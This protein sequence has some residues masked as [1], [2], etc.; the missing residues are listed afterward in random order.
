MRKVYSFLVAAVAMITA[1]SCAQEIDNLST[2]NGKAIFTAYADGA[3]T[4]TVLGMNEE[5]EKPLSMWNGEEWIQIV[6]KGN[7]WMNTDTDGPSA[8]AKIYYNGKNGK[9]DE[10]DGVYAVYPAGDANYTLAKGLV[11]GVSVP[12]VQTATPDSYDPKAA[13]AIA[14][15]ENTELHFINVTSLLKFQVASEGVKSVT[16][17]PNGSDN[18]PKISG[19]CSIGADGALIPWTTNEHES[20]SYVELVA[21]DEG[22]KVGVDYYVALF[23]CTLETGFKVEFSF[24]GNKIEIASYNPEE[25]LVLPRN[26]I[27]NIGSLECEVPEWSIAG[28]LNNWNTLETPFVAEGDYWVAKSVSFK[29]SGKFKIIN[30]GSVWRSISE[31]FAVGKWFAISDGDDISI[32]AGT[33]DFYL[34]KDGKNLQVVSAGSAAPL[35]PG[36][37][38]AKEGWVYLKPNSNWTQAGARFAIYLCNGS[39]AAK[40]LSMSRVDGTS[41]YGVQLPDDYT[42]ANYKNIIFVRM[43]PANNTNNWNNKWNQ[44][45]DLA[46]SKIL[47]DNYNCCTINNDQW[48]AGSNVTWSNITQL[49]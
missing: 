45:G 14:Y 36:K 31:S 21:G 19:K 16:I 20:E 24:G 18:L 28:T 44:T 34:T 42:V 15:T 2:D 43:N 4:K 40:W 41:Y 13:V 46:S 38:A 6:G 26:Q 27:L 23:P 49:N 48:D 39:K 9:F 5:T 3:D 1:A 11:T 32:P 29:E 10:T 12:T 47:T 8:S 22:F 25:A 7:Y 30:K 35:A 37:I 17:A 33:Y